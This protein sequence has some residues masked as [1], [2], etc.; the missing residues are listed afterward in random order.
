M[1]YTLCGYWIYEA[2]ILRLYKTNTHEKYA[3]TGLYS[4]IVL[5]SAKMQRLP[6]SKRQKLSLHYHAKYN[7]FEKPFQQGLENNVAEKR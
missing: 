2:K 5:Q 7:I 3:I 4:S 6:K 1:K